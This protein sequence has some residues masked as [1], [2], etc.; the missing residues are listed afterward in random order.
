MGVS[1][2]EEPGVIWAADA[3]EGKGSYS[4]K[5]KVYRSKY[6]VLSEYKF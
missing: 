5:G 3:R 6:V 1:G 4:V 2:C